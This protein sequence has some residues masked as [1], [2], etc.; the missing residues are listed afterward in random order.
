MIDPIGA[1]LGVVVLTVVL[2]EGNLV[3]DTV[4]GVAGAAVTGIVVRLGAA[5]LLLLALRYY[6]IPD[7]LRSP[8]AVATAVVAFAVTNLLF[9]EG[10]LFATTVLGIALANQ[11]RV[12]VSDIAAFE[13]ALGAMILGALF[14]LLG[15]RIELSE[16][17]EVWVAG[18]ALMVAWNTAWSG[19]TGWWNALALPTSTTCHVG[20]RGIRLFLWYARHSA[21][22]C[23]KRLSTS[24]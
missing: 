12:D 13:K 2:R 5:A 22:M 21:P 23:L 24:G 11:R 19:S 10:G 17:A 14:V 18:I 16:L 9:D 8:V 3:R 20:L 6:R 1:S 7:L 15:A 4:L